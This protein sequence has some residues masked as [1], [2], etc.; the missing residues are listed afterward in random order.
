[1]NRRGELVFRMPVT[2]ELTPA[3]IRGLLDQFIRT[4]S[5]LD[6]FLLDYFPAVYGNLS[7]GMDRTSRVNL[8]LRQ[9]SLAEILKHLVERLEP[10]KREQLDAMLTPQPPPNS[11]NLP[12]EVA[13]KASSLPLVFFVY[14]DKDEP[15]IEELLRQL[16]PSERRQLLRTFS[17]RNIRP[18]ED[19]RR[20][21][22]LHMEQAALIV[23]VISSELLADQTFES[24][25][26]QAQ[27][28]ARQGCTVIPLLARPA[29]WEQTLFGPLQ[30]LPTD[31]RFI[32]T[33][34]RPD[35]E[36]VLVEI[37]QALL[38]AVQ[39]APRPAPDACAPV[40]K[41]EPVP[42]QSGPTFQGS[43]PF[44]VPTPEVQGLVVPSESDE[45][46]LP[47]L[48]L[49]PSF[50]LHLSDLHFS[51]AHQV[52]PF[53]DAL[54]ADLQEL[55]RLVPRLDGVVISGD[56]TQ[57]ADRSEF[58]AAEE[59]VRELR[60][61]YKLGP[62][63]VILVP[64]N[65][66][67]SWACSR[68]AYPEPL[69]PNAKP[70]ETNYKRRF[71][72]FADFYQA[73]CGQPYPLEFER[74][75]MLHPLAA[76]RVLFL[77]LNSAWQCDHRPEHRGRAAI[78]EVA[79]S[80]ALRTIRREPSYADWL[81]VAVWHH[82][83][84]SDGEDRIRNTGFLDRLAQAGFRLGMHGHM[85]SA[86]LGQH[87]YD[88]TAN[89]RK[90][91]LVGAG[92]FGAPTKDWRHGVPLQYQILCIQRAQVKVLSRCR[93]NPEGPWRGDGRWVVGTQARTYYEL[94]L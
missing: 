46:L 54:E 83:V 53:I 7:S 72:A 43:Q 10:K 6:A 33:R 37:V 56:L 52:T 74:Q 35:R 62:Q 49:P 50:F 59:F 84:Q 79:L 91:R 30:P 1:M 90:L 47:K 61:T 45:P 68:A 16:A 41:A 15:L 63:Q 48:E 66:D 80:S 93:E 27:R 34:S 8:L 12:A 81:K 75:A 20:T 13:H 55:Q 17:R 89:G 14:D 78:N 65:H 24:F 2:Q 44:R 18:G 88:V 26:Q 40:D 39:G 9:E 25:A 77:G 22:M 21:T 36:V 58:A 5:D 32:G 67:G 28:L 31:R 57:V 11:P 94:D 29:M 4:S 71:E 70:D 73:L 92:T 38:H 76:H 23:P 19:W 60:Q 3:L 42:A 69:T 82:P 85:H 64:G 87:T 86:Q 51:S